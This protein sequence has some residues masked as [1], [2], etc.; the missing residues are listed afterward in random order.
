MSINELQL[1]YDGICVYATILV[2]ANTIGKLILS[3]INLVMLG[4]IT[5]FLLSEIFHAALVF[6]LFEIFVI[7][8]TLW[9]LFGEERL[10]INAKSLSY[11]QHYGFFT[12]QLHTISFNKKIMILPYD[13]VTERDQTYMKLYF[14][15]YNE[16]NLPELIYHSVIFQQLILSISFSK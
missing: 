3:F 14:E 1:R 9:N 2:K 13:E 16:H 5:T 10:I 12:S 4:I 11:Q 15:S 6:M 8:Y 7:K